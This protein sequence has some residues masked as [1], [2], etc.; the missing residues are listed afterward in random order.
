[1]I[2]KR[3]QSP[4]SCWPFIGSNKIAL[5]HQS[6]CLHFPLTQTRVLMPVRV[7]GAEHFIVQ[8]DIDVFA[9]VP[10]DAFV[11]AC[12]ADR[13]KNLEFNF[14]SIWW[15]SLV[16][17]LMIGTVA[18]CNIAVPVCPM[19]I[20]I[21]PQPAIRPRRPVKVMC[22]VG[23]QIG[24]MWFLNQALHIISSGPIGGKVADCSLITRRYRHLQQRQ[25]ISIWLRHPKPKS[26]MDNFSCYP[27]LFRRQRF[28]NRARVLCIQF[29]QIDD[30][31]FDGRLL[32]AMRRRHNETP[33][34]YQICKN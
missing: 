6:I 21:L 24:C 10:I 23:R 32:N 2:C 30:D 16:H 15:C 9:F 29:A 22:V 26:W 20:S 13:S 4:S 3:T 8:L 11:G 18:V 28:G 34:Y 19:L 14:M 17:S 1:M 31:V 5:R 33:R 12:S 25:V 27:M 7:T